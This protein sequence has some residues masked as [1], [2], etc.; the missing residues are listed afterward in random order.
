MT[1]TPQPN[2]KSRVSVAWPPFEKALAAVL[3]RLVEDQYLI[4]LVKQTNRFIQFAAQGSFGIRVEATSNHYLSKQ[5]KL[6]ERQIAALIEAGWQAPT[7]KPNESTPE[8]DPDGSSNF[9][10]EFA[11]PASFEAVARLTIRTLTASITAVSRP[12]NWARR[13]PC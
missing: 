1:A 12:T 8:N 6:D 10:A 11:S 4:L 2:P 9:Y 7:G 3:E 13:R 5:E